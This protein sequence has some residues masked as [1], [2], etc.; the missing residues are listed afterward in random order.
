MLT[1]STSTVL[2]MLRRLSPRSWRRAHGSNS[3][4]I[5]P[6]PPLIRG[7]TSFVPLHDIS[8]GAGSFDHGRNRLHQDLQ[9][10]PERPLIDVLHVQLHPLIKAEIAASVDLPETGD[11]WPDTEASPVPVL[12]ETVIVAQ[13]QGP[14]A[15]KAHVASQHVDELRQLVNAGL[16]E[17]PTKLSDSGIVPDLEY[18]PTGLIEDLQVLLS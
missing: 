9:V 17:E 18:R 16:P 4:P 3:V 15:Y 11:T 8:S 7:S 2:R 12:I 6:R 14:R 13:G 10:E 5:R 1:P